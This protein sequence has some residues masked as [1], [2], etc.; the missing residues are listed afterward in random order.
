[1]PR[2][3]TYFDQVGQELA[4]GDTIA[5]KFNMRGEWYTGV[6]ISFTDMGNPR[7]LRPVTNYDPVTKVWVPAHRSHS[8]KEYIKIN[9]TK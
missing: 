8:T 5:Y 7:I 9:L 6:V 4:I 1:M 3:Q 2:N